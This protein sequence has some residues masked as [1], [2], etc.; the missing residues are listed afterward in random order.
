MEIS[1]QPLP[2]L[3]KKKTERQSIIGDQIVDRHRRLV[4]DEAQLI[5]Y[6]DDFFFQKTHKDFHHFFIFI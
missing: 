6:F 2:S 1:N 4:N 3:N 5:L